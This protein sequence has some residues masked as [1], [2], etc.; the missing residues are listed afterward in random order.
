MWGRVIREMEATMRAT[1]VFAVALMAVAWLPATAADGDTVLGV[2]ATDP[3]NEDGQAHI[4]IYKAGETYAGKIIWLEEPVYPPDDDG[5]MA[6][7]EK[8]DRENPDESLRSRP[9][10][11]LEL[12]SGFEYAGDGKWKKGVIYAPDEGKTYKCKLTLADDGS[13]N[14]RGFIGVSLLGRTEQWTRVSAED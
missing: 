12:M 9:V 2:W 5:G 8:V 11:G 6:G 7:K 4:E 14:V 13:L 10:L 1:V 3:D